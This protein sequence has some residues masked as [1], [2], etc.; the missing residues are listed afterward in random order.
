MGC[1]YW[2]CPEQSAETLRDGWLATGDL[3]HMDKD[4]FF[5]I[6]GRKKDMI[7][8]SRFNVYPAEVEQILARFPSVIESAVVGKP[9]PDRGEIVYAFIVHGPE[10]E[11]DPLELDAHCRTQPGTVTL[12]ES[13]SG[14]VDLSAGGT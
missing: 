7:L 6:D 3:A 12:I 4:G 11:I 5:Y 10:Q 14:A 9:D 8:T 1:G 2:N 13:F